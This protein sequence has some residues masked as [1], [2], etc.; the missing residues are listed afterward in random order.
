MKKSNP[1]T[2]NNSQI[3]SSKY[4]WKLPIEV[5]EKLHE[6]VSKGRIKWNINKTL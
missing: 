5:A 2:Q 3:I 4:G 6:Y 1:T